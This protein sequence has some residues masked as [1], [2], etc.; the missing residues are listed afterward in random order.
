MVYFASSV[1]FPE[2]QDVSFSEI[3]EPQNIFISRNK[4]NFSPCLFH[5]FFLFCYF[6]STPNKV[7]YKQQAAAGSLDVG[8]C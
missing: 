7:N 3:L 8:V 5:T 2:G 1:P 6:S 4:Y